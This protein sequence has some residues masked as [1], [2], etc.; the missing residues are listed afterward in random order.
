MNTPGNLKYSKTHE[1]VRTEGD[2]TEIGIT[3]F[4]VFVYKTIFDKKR[5][6]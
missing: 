4:D 2:L 5:K 1:W 3:D 6:S